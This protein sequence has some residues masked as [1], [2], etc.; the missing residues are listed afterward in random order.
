MRGARTLLGG[1]PPFHLY[2]SP[3]N[4]I[5]LLYAVHGVRTL[6]FRVVPH[7]LLALAALWCSA[8]PSW[9]FPLSPLRAQVVHALQFGGGLPPPILLG[10]VL[11]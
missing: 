4:P 9:G 7:F 8:L 3:L 2:F 5:S 11:G 6:R 1:W 10:C